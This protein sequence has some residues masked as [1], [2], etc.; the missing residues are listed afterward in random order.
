MWSKPKPQ[1]QSL[2]AKATTLKAKQRPR[3][4]FCGLRPRLRP[5]IT[6]A[7]WSQRQ[8]QDTFCKPIA[9]IR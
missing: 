3:P 5:N 8:R 7:E 4:T 2:K 1:G 9:L 6:A